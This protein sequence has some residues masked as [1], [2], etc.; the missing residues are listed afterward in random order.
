MTADQGKGPEPENARSSNVV[1]RTLTG[2]SFIEKA[3]LLIL[4]AVLS[5]V[6]VPIVINRLNADDADRR[7]QTEIAAAES[8]KEAEIAKS[9][10]DALLRARLALLDEFSEVLLTYETLALDVSWYRTPA[11]NDLALHE[12]AYSRYTDR[13]VELFSKWRVLTSRAQLLAGPEISKQMG[14]FQQK[15]FAYQ[16]TPLTELHRRRTVTSNEWQAQHMQSERMLTSANELILQL[17]TAMG[18]G[19]P[20]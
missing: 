20:K 6:A 7:K 8:R 13:V 18:V 15:V 17:G 12:K 14:S 9:K 3:A 16:D 19:S 11:V 1:R 4:T 10:T 5:G 2:G